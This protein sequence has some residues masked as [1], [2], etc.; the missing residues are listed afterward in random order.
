MTSITLTGPAGGYPRVYGLG[1][2]PGTDV[3]RPAQPPEEGA[4]AVSGQPS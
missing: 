4:L 1:R 3:F 2:K